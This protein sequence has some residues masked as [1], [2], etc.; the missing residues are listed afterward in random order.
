MGFVLYH[1]F[2]CIFT[3]GVT[4][5][6]WYRAKFHNGSV[7]KKQKTILPLLSHLAIDRDWVTIDGG[8]QRLSSIWESLR[9]VSLFPSHSSQPMLLCALLVVLSSCSFRQS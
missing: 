6:K 9:V 8:Q 4:T 3:I 2:L 5:S 7:L 1:A